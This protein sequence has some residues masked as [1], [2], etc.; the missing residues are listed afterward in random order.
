M[1]QDV[2][3]SD[4]VRVER[5]TLSERLRD[6]HHKDCAWLKW[7]YLTGTFT[8]KDGW[9]KPD[10]CDCGQFQLRDEVAALEQENRM[11][12]VRTSPQA[13]PCTCPGFCLW[14]ERKTREQFVALE[15]EREDFKLAFT[16]CL[17]SRSEELRRLQEIIEMAW[18]GYGYDQEWE[19]D[20]QVCAA[21]RTRTPHDTDGGV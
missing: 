14:H 6:R 21:I 17:K 10:V 3:G 9:S 1:I 7:Y 20:C 5:R 15:Q 13:E 19:C 11:L 12:R 2:G 16:D 4:E 8:P 18:K